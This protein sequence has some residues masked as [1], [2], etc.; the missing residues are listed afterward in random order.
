MFKFFYSFLLL[1]IFACSLTTDD[2]LNKEWEINYLSAG[3]GNYSLY[4]VTQNKSSRAFLTF[5]ED[6]VILKISE[7]NWSDTVFSD[8]VNYSF[9]KK[10]VSFRIRR[11]GEIIEV[12]DG[13]VDHSQETSNNM[14]ITGTF[15]Y[16]DKNYNKKQ[17]D[18]KLYLKR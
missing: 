4:S 10:N 12:Q 3:L 17:T 1:L 5:L 8:Y 14:S 18:R 6:K 9:S 7:D 15:I 13:E 2:Y 11:N 16:I